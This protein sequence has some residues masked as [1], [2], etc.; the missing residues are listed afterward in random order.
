[1][2]QIDRSALV[3]HSAQQMFDVVNNVHFYPDF[4]P[5]C[6]SSHVISH[7]EGEMVA[8]LKLAK[9]G[10]HYSFTTRNKLSVPSEI[11]LS[12]EEGPFKELSGIWSFSPLSD[13][14]CKVSLK[15]NFEFSGKI[16]SLAM[17]KVFGQIANTMVEAFVQRADEIYK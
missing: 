17:A 1:M 13:D 11:Q 16:A 5:W 15:L 4:L 2:T 6:S 14:A 8:S 7:E 10:M 3:L 9:A 12:L